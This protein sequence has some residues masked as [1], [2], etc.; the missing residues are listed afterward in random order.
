MS[1]G[2]DMAVASNGAGEVLDRPEITLLDIRFFTGSLDEGIRLVLAGGLIVFPSGP[3]L[4]QD[5]VQSAAYHEA[6]SNADLVFADSGAMV[7]LWRMLTGTKVPRH[8]GLRVLAELL[9]RSELR[10]VDALFWV[11]PDQEQMERNLSWLNGKGIPAREAACYLAPRYGQGFLDDQGLLRRIEENRPRF[12]ILGIGGGVQE[13]L[14]LYLRNTLSYRPSIICIGAAIGFLTGAQAKIPNWADRF[15]LGW[16]FRCLTNP[17]VFVPRYFRALTI[18]RVLFQHRLTGKIP[19]V[20]AEAAVL[21][22][23]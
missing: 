20:R 3:G 17:R 10:E 18:V 19:K 4:A 13:R 15:F 9:M 5:L 14:G 16:F 7:L 2:N 23:E 21:Q 1:S 12:V 6:L 22:R 11:M 8:S